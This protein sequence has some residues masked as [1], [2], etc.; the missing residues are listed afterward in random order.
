M[1][2][3]ILAPAP[4][5]APIFS[6]SSCPYD[7][8]AGYDEWPMQW[9]KDWGGGKK[10]YCCERVGRGCPS[11][12]PPPSGIPPSGA[13]A[14]VLS[15]DTEL[16]KSLCGKILKSLADIATNEVKSIGVFTIPGLLKIKTRVKPATK[17]GRREVFGKVVMVKAKPARKVVKA[18]PLSALKKSI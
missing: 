15:T 2:F 16:K 3:S 12:L 17:A 9:V 10:D 5:A 1:A 14:E 7:C 18:F 11:E 4:A 13:I 6:T 8:N